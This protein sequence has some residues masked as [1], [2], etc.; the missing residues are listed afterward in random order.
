MKLLDL[1]LEDIKIPFGNKIVAT[2]INDLGKKISINCEVPKT[3]EEQATGLMYRDNLCDNCGMYYDYVDSGFWMKNVS[4]P[5]EMIFIKG[6][7]IVEIKKALAN[8]ETIISPTVNCDSNL[9]VNND[10]CQTN[11]ISVGN[12]IYTS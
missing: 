4:F 8:D 10:F 9:E 11:N 1:I 2:I 3:E 12:K 5:I 7:T 6:D